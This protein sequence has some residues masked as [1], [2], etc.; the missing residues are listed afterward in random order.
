MDPRNAWRRC[1]ARVRHVS[2]RRPLL[3]RGTH[4]VGRVRPGQSGRRPAEWLDYY[5]RDRRADDDRAVAAATDRYRP[6]TGCARRPTA[7][8]R[9]FDARPWSRRRGV[10]GNA[11]ARSPS[12]LSASIGRNSPAIATLRPTHGHPG[13][14]KI[15]RK[16]MG[17][18]SWRQD[19]GIVPTRRNEGRCA[20]RPTITERGAAPKI[21]DSFSPVRI[22]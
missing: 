4:C 8:R 13:R 5:R 20:P 22:R 2:S 12:P 15:R 14:S 11:D 3:R 18:W 1:G 16:C 17:C 6:S 10:F 21:Q 7:I 9:G 19:C